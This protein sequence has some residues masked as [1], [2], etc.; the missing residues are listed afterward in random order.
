MRTTVKRAANRQTVGPELFYVRNGSS[1]LQL[2]LLDK[3]TGR[4]GM[5]SVCHHHEEFAYSARHITT[6]VSELSKIR[7]DAFTRQYCFM[8]CF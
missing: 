2:K 3:Q 1:M 8:K 4:Y 6:I 7:D 5:Y